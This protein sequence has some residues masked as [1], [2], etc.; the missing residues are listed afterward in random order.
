M[1]DDINSNTN[2]DA[3]S[4]ASII[5]SSWIRKKTIEVG[6]HGIPPGIISIIHTYS[7]RPAQ[8]SSIFSA[9]CLFLKPHVQLQLTSTNNN[10]NNNTNTNS[11][12][13]TQIKTMAGYPHQQQQQQRRQQQQ[14]QQ[15]PHKI[16]KHLRNLSPIVRLFH[17]LLDRISP[18]QSF[19]EQLYQI[20]KQLNYSANWEKA[21]STM[22]VQIS[23]AN[24]NIPID[25][26]K[27]K[28]SKHSNKKSKSKSQSNK[29]SHKGG[30]KMI[31]YFSQNCESINNIINNTPITDSSTMKA[32]PTLQSSPQSQPLLLLYMK[33]HGRNLNRIRFGFSVDPQAIQLCYE[34]GKCNQLSKCGGGG[35]GLN[36][37]YGGL[38]ID[39]DKLWNFE[40]HFDKIAYYEDILS[41]KW[42]F[43]K[44]FDRNIKNR[45]HYRD[46]FDNKLRSIMNKKPL[47]LYQWNDKNEAY[48]CVF[49]NKK[50]IG[51]GEGSEFILLENVFKYTW[52]DYNY[53]YGTSKGLRTFYNVMNF[54]TFVENCRVYKCSDCEFIILW[55][56]ND[57]YQFFNVDKNGASNINSNNNNNKNNIDSK[58]NSNRSTKNNK[59]WNG[60]RKENK[61]KNGQKKERATSVG[62]HFKT[63]VE[64]CYDTL[65]LFVYVSN[66]KSQLNIVRLK[67]IFD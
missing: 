22:Y 29:Q 26:V 56:R 19:E 16:P 43:V 31:C 6:T 23:I 36:I 45:Y 67:S 8:I 9:N 2:I 42:N 17:T 61:K 47:K 35:V 46:N 24:T 38:G 48:T 33:Q 37:N 15:S 14:K 11:D 18:I 25:S 64:Q 34:N 57:F 54:D 44:G 62:N 65:V 52:K 7:N 1:S 20:T 63:N 28:S 59:N 27:F 49:R 53:I 30:S 50:N 39:G 58:N 13:N 12:T 40:K 10:T 66:I 51:K 55:Q 32:I 5:V 4:V 41:L 60:K 3:E 21:C